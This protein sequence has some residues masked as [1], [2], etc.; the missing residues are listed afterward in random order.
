MRSNI[1]PARWT[2]IPLGCTRLGRVHAAHVRYLI[3][4]LQMQRNA[5]CSTLRRNQTGRDAETFLVRI[6]VFGCIQIQTFNF[7]I[8]SIY[9]TYIIFQLYRTNFNPN[10]QLWREVNGSFSHDN[11]RLQRM[12]TVTPAPI[13]IR[14]APS[15][16]VIDMSEGFRSLL[17]EPRAN[18][19][20][21]RHLEIISFCINFSGNVKF[22][23]VLTYFF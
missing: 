15:N 4:G 10:F 18:R 21:G 23:I 17:A 14:A 7:F 19:T 13:A 2:P 5:A 22:N 16:F 8:T 3:V 9:Y 20:T 1:G 12:D 6:W 11:H